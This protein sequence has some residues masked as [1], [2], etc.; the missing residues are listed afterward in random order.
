MFDSTKQIF[1]FHKDMNI[2]I[3]DKKDIPYQILFGSDIEKNIRLDIDFIK[4]YLTIFNQSSQSET[5]MACWCY[6]IHHISNILNLI[7]Y[8]NQWINYAEI[9][10][11]N[12]WKEYLKINPQAQYEWSSLQT[13]LNRLL[14]NWLISWYSKLATVE[15][16]KNAIDSW[17][18]IYTWS[19]NWDWNVVKNTHIYETK[20]KSYWHLFCICWYDDNWFIAINSN[21]SINW[22]FNIP[23][24][25]WDT[26]YSRYAV[27]D[28]KD[29]WVYTL[30]NNLKSK[31]DLLSYLWYSVYYT[32]I[33]N[34]YWVYSKQCK[35]LKFL[36]QN[37]FR[38]RI[39]E[40]LEDII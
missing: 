34:K 5:K 30:Y 19:M 27:S 38:L 24:K 9:N 35:I 40:R 18:W 6:W 32:N 15:E 14:D 39:Q 4:K 3:P 16:A 11:L 29:L 28:K 8:S 37:K 2:D 17:K 25:Y 7:E 33:S 22:Y 10:P 20:D 26:L 21:W 36:W 13:W 31:V 23:Y 1:N 12:P